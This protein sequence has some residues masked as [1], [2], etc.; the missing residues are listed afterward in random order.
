MGKRQ[1]PKT[2]PAEPQTGYSLTF[3]SLI[4]LGVS[5]LQPHK[6]FKAFS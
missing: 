1:N 4:T 6:G 3:F 2:V 5:S